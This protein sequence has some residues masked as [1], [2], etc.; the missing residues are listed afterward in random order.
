MPDPVDPHLTPTRPVRVLL[1]IKSLGHGG[2]EQLVVD[3]VAN[4]DHSAFEYEVAHIF[5]SERS[6]APTLAA[7]GTPVHALGATR[8]FDVRWMPR[9]RSLLQQGDYDVV[10]FHLPYSAALGRLVVACVPARTRPVT[11][12]TE[13][14]MW[15]KVSP[16]VK[17][18]NRATVHRDKALIAVSGAAY[19]ALPHAL[20]PRAQVIVHGVDLSRLTAADGYD[21]EVR[22]EV[23]AE[24]GIPD[25][26]VLVVTVAN[27][28]AE[29]GYDVLLDA[30]RRVAD[31][32]LPIRFV[33]AGQGSL[34]D[35]LVA[36]RDELE[37]GERFRFLG[38]RSDVLRLLAAADVFV[39][40]SHQEGLP[41]VLMEAMSMGLAI[42]ATSVGGVPQV[43]TDGT[44]GLLVPPG[45]AGALAR[46]IESVAVDLDLRRLLGRR[47]KQDSAAFDAARA[48]GEIE[49]VYR[50][51]L[52]TRD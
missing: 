17:T 26:E 44:N 42:V 2:A 47:A 41:V 8:N 6:F 35:E 43:I 34:E 52:R 28:R 25:D 48:S 37:L 20:K 23:R 21:G 18:L 19:D 31:R 9:F 3:T 22:G 38:Y 11:I 10:H 7:G 39:L 45:D 14:S 13:H 40:P 16:V 1:V 4:G 50:R 32:R 15:N 24:L 46:A 33:A 5:E 29:K 49:Q 12:Y 27:L 30:A 36:R 51:V